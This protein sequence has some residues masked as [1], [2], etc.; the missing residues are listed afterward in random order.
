MHFI[1][2]GRATP[3]SPRS[4]QARTFAMLW[5][6]TYRC[7]RR[8]P[9]AHIR[10]NARS[11]SRSPAAAITE[12]TARPVR[13]IRLCR[14]RACPSTFLV[15]VLRD[16]RESTAPSSAGLRPSAIAHARG[17]EDALWRFCTLF[18]SCGRQHSSACNEKLTHHFHARGKRICSYAR[19]YP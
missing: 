9:L 5:S 19:H 6:G 4:A 14:R 13:G 7:A 12:G 3:Q 11:S 17:R 1:L 2:R 8:W 18:T 16:D 10:E 15:P